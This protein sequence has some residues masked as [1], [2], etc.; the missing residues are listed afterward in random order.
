M[1][2]FVETWYTRRM[3]R[4]HKQDAH[5]T[6]ERWCTLCVKDAHDTFWEN[7]PTDLGSTNRPLCYPLVVHSVGMNRC[8]ILHAAGPKICISCGVHMTRWSSGQRQGRPQGKTMQR[9][10]QGRHEARHCK[11]KVD[12][13]ARLQRQGEAQ[14]N[15]KTI[16]P[17]K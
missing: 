7:V 15:T 6:W 1:I 3:Q 16:Q 10:R 5:K 2:H 17:T 14:G 12:K 13:K 9:Q 11:D 8:F 4:I